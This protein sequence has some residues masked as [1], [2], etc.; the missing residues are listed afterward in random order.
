[1]EESPTVEEPTEEPIG[2]TDESATLLNE[3]K[4]LGVERAEQLQGMATASQQAGNLANMVGSLKR[5]ISELKE[6]RVEPKVDEY[7]EPQQIDINTVVKNA[8]REVQTEQVKEQAEARQYILNELSY[9]Q[10]DADYQN[11]H[12]KEMWD[13]HIANPTIQSGINNR[14]TTVNR[15]YNNVVKGYLK[16]IAKRTTSFLETNSSLPGQTSIPHTE[17]NQPGQAP[18]EPDERTE[19]INTARKDWKGGDDDLA[20]LIK[21][22]L[23]PDDPIFRV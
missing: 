21:A 1:M 6:S 9:V 15:E 5:E 7:G 12:I 23:P 11:P 20:R 14:Q 22:T 13:K 3:L 2:T 17:T 19:N 16:E 4:E 8:I 18:K 10:N